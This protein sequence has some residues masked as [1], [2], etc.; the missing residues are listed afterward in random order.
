MTNCAYDGVR[1]LPPMGLSVALMCPD[2]PRWSTNWRCFSA[3]SI[4]G[5]G[6]W[7]ATRSRFNGSGLRRSARGH[8][9]RPIRWDALR[10]S[11]GPW[12]TRPPRPSLKGGTRCR[13]HHSTSSG[14]WWDA[15]GR[16]R[17]NL[18]ASPA[19]RPHDGQRDAAGLAIPV[20]LVSVAVADSGASAPV[21]RA[22]RVRRTESLGP[23]L[24]SRAAGTSL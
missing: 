18:M 4:V 23:N 8:R 17:V 10:V 19:L 15:V 13:E 22:T 14:T 9:P 2:G 11:A 20:A 16:G 5:R 24:P 12:S 3:C 7:P 1:W 21:R 6:D